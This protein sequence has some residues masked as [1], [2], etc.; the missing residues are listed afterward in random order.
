MGL[1][2]SKNNS[3]NADSIKLKEFFEGLIK[4]IDGE[5]KKNCVFIMDNLSNNTS[6]KNENNL[7]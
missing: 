3:S 7:F 6:E 2:Y 1:L 4:F 5:R